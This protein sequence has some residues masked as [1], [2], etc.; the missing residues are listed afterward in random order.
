ML[1]PLVTTML[2]SCLIPCRPLLHMESS[3]VENVM[4]AQL[5]DGPVILAKVI[6]IHGTTFMAVAQVYKMVVTANI[7]Y[8]SFK[9]ALKGVSSSA[10]RL[11]SNSERMKLSQLGALQLR[12]NSAQLASVSTIMSV[13]RGYGLDPRVMQGLGQHTSSNTRV[14]MLPLVPSPAGAQVTAYA[15][16]YPVNLDMPSYAFTSAQLHAHKYGL[17]AIKPA[18]ANNP[19]LVQQLERLKHFATTPF[20]FS[21]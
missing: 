8:E 20:D 1:R 16:P 17:L 4:V 2:A 21:R 19:E 14:A 13:L 10:M 5:D 9:N 7:T 15:G 11:A 18:A 3:T 6:T 12:A